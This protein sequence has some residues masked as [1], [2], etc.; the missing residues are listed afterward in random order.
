MEVVLLLVDGLGGVGRHAVRAVPVEGLVELRAVLLERLAHL[1]IINVRIVV[2]PRCELEQLRSLFAASP[3]QVMEL[4]REID[5]S[6]D[7]LLDRTEF[8]LAIRALGL[9]LPK[10]ELGLLFQQLDPDGSGEIEYHELKA[11]LMGQ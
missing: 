10:Q 11:S 1:Q 7:G 5:A 4:F 6:G 9:R 2:E 8:N 3:A